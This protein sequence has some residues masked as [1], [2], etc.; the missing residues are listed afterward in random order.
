MTLL[1]GATAAAEQ[2]VALLA[3]LLR[4][5]KA[6]FAQARDLSVGAGCRAWIRVADSPEADAWL[7]AWGPRSS[8]GKHDHGGSRG[9]VH[10]LRGAL[11]ERSWPDG[12]GPV[13]VRQLVPGSTL[14]VPPDRV[15]DVF[16]EGTSAALSLHVYSPRL[17]TMGFYPAAGATA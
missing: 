17:T 8:V 5:P 2:A 16:N 7:I 12:D 9:A 13:A 3:E 4:S 11:V 1:I 15:H 6:L 10:V 14:H